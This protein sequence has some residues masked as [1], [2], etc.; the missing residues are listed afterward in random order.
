MHWSAKIGFATYA[1]A[2]GLMAWL[3]LSLRVPWFVVLPI[4]AGV[5]LLLPPVIGL[6]WGLWER[7]GLPSPLAT[8]LFTKPSR[9]RYRTGD[10]ALHMLACLPRED[11]VRLRVGHPLVTELPAYCAR[12]EDGSWLLW[13]T[14]GLAGDVIEVEVSYPGR[15]EHT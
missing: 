1:I 14:P 11:L 10:G 8:T 2:A 13:P 12:A 15:A 6:V 9:Y 4:G 3:W 5:A 7:R